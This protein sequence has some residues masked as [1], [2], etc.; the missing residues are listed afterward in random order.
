MVVCSYCRG[1]GPW[2]PG[3]KGLS[4]ERWV[5]GSAVH[6]L[7]TLTSLASLLLLLLLLSAILSQ[8]QSFTYFSKRFSLFRRVI[9]LHVSLPASVL[10][11]Q[12]PLPSSK[13][14]K[15]LRPCESCQK[16]LLE[17]VLTLPHGDILR[18]VSGLSA[19][20]ESNQGLLGLPSR[21]A[22]ARQMSLFPRWT[23]YFHFLIGLLFFCSY[24]SLWPC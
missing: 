17:V 13:V 3:N 5:S 15:S 18:P 11:K 24:F 7:A 21:L 14:S 8:A 16:T 20:R 2:F 10:L 12:P 22:L 6:H 4:G 9:H 19:S 1:E 23:L